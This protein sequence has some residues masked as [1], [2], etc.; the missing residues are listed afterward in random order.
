[1]DTLHPAPSWPSRSAEQ[2]VP[3]PKTA[4]GESCND[5]YL[6]LTKADGFVVSF[7]YT[8]SLGPIP[9]H[10]YFEHLEGEEGA[11]EAYE[12]PG[13]GYRSLGISACEGKV[14][15]A[16]LNVATI[17]AAIQEARQ[18]RRADAEHSRLWT[19]RGGL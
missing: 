3:T 12:H 14:P 5:T 8:T 13:A 9:S 11:L 15:F 1:M 7:E 2:G 10:D 4:P 16:R 6:L 19:G 17:S 18:D